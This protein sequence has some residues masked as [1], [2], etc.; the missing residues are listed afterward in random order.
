M[1]CLRR[2]AAKRLRDANQVAIIAK[3]AG[4][5][6]RNRM[7]PDFA[8][9]SWRW[10]ARIQISSRSTHPVADY[11]ARA[12]RAEDCAATLRA[13][14][15]GAGAGATDC[16]HRSVSAASLLDDRSAALS[17]SG[18]GFHSGSRLERRADAARISMHLRS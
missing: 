18:T 6:L 16:T 4:V 7:R 2:I 11:H 5:V 3:A 14:Y 12:E 8:S 15:R 10:H 13:S 17:R 9:Q 1:N